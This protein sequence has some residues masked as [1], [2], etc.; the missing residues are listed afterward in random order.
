MNATER[1]VY[2]KTIIDRMNIDGYIATQAEIM[3]I[4][5]MT[6]LYQTRNFALNVRILNN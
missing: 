6:E 5:I 4:F 1:E 2:C 3:V